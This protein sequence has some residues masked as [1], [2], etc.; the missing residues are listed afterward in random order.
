M[1]ADERSVRCSKSVYRV[2]GNFRAK[3]LPLIRWLVL[4]LASVLCMTTAAHAD[5]TKL[6]D[7]GKGILY[8]DYGRVKTDR[9]TK[10]VWTLRT[11]K[12]LVTSGNG[13][14]F[15]SEMTL[16]RVNCSSDTIS[17]LAGVFYSDHDGFGQMETTPLTTPRPKGK[18]LRPRRSFRTAMGS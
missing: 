4:L 15:L 1:V 3:K 16:T 10:K 17:L 12:A 13:H 11:Y 9:N 7:D 5:W 14:R 2:R 6:G 18:M 8:V